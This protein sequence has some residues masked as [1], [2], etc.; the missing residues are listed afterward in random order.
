[1]PHQVTTQPMS[2]PLR[3]SGLLIQLASLNSSIYLA[4]QDEI[5]PEQWK[6]AKERYDR[7]KKIKDLVD[8]INDYYEEQERAER[9][10]SEEAIDD[11]TD[12]DH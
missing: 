5:I 10:P 4:Q 1:M 6:K 3:A 7:A 9:P 11:I 12:L 8:D 2:P